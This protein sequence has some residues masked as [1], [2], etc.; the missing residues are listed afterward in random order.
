MPK[1]NR[2]EDII[3]Q[4]KVKDYLAY[5]KQEERSEATRK[6]YGRD[7]RQFL[8]YAGGKTLT[9]E[10][11]ICYKEKLQE[12]YQPVSVNAKLAAIN[13]F[14]AFIGRSELKVRQ[15]K[16]QRQPF[17]PKEKELTK[18]EYLRLVAAAEE[19]QNEK[20]SLLLQTICGTGIR[21]SELRFITAEAVSAGRAVIR[22]KGKSRAALISGKLRK[23][24]LR[25]L[26]QQK[27]KAG[28]VFTTRTGRPLD[29][30]NIWK[31][32][33]SLCESAGVAPEKVF[34]H[35]LRHLFARCFYALDK[36]IAKLADILGHSSINTTRIYIISTGKEHLRQIEA[37][38]LVV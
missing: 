37:L 12:S 1:K 26:R 17:C 15:L 5:L 32:M 13:G 30:S 33:K 16:I 29:R 3:M 22:L 21:V 8:L 6:Q 19:K 4:E 20:L 34:P 36:D 35:N 38:G 7:I 11:V 9:K 23:S 31:M 24:L 2:R 14:F 10:L 18:A 25:Y 27:I 28:P